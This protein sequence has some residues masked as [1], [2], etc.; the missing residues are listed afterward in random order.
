MSELV[1]RDGQGLVDVG[2]RLRPL[3]ERSGVLGEDRGL[4]GH[5]VGAVEPGLEVLDRQDHAQT[6]IP[7]NRALQVMLV[8]LRLR[9]LGRFLLHLFE[10]IVGDGPGVGAGVFWVDSVGDRLG[11]PDL[12][13]PFRDRLVE[14]IGDLL[15]G[16]RLRGGQLESVERAHRRV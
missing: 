4:G 5:G 3:L 12:L 10:N 9:F 7:G 13:P 11:A 15:L 1:E 2:R 14:T 6:G 8:L 16:Q